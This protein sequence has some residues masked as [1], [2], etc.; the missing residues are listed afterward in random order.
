MISVTLLS[1]FSQLPQFRY[2]SNTDCFAL[3]K[4]IFSPVP[5][6]ASPDV[7]HRS[8]PPCFQISAQMTPQWRSQSWTPSSNLTRRS[9]VLVLFLALCFSVVIITKQ[10]YDA[11]INYTACKW[12]KRRMHRF[13]CLPPNLSCSFTSSVFFCVIYSCSHVFKSLAIYLLR[14]Y[15]ASGFKS[16][17]GDGGVTKV[18]S[19]TV[20]PPSWSSIHWGRQDIKPLL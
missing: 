11:D 1:I 10:P 18:A 2:S 17:S 12:L 4:Y 5:R 3:I 6:T 13:H 19:C 7:H 20:S 9:C 8:P 14:S 15:F 16:S